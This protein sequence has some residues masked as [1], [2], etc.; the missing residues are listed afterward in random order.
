VVRRDY[1]GHVVT[2]RAARLSR[3]FRGLPE[4]FRI[5]CLDAMTM[6]RDCA[7]LAE[8]IAKHG[9]IVAEEAMREL[10]RSDPMWWAK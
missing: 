10:D 6:L 8:V 9:K 5:R 4:R 7:K 3:E 2:I 1:H